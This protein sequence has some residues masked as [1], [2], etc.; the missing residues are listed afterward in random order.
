MATTRTESPIKNQA[1][2]LAHLRGYEAARTEAQRSKS[3]Q[4]LFGSR[5]K[6]WLEA[7]P[8]EPIR[9]G[10]TGLV[11]E[12]QKRSGASRMDVA[13]LPD[14]LLLWAARMGLLNADLKAWTALKDKFHEAQRMSQFLT[15]GGESFALRV[16]NDKE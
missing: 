2:A 12:L 9:D 10:E 4:D 14:E 8:G 7:H 11:G 6:E 16:Y 13:S 15:P 1:D 5:L 3:A